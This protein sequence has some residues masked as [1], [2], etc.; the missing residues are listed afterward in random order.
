MLLQSAAMLARKLLVET[1]MS[2]GRMLSLDCQYS[3]MKNFAV[4]KTFA[5]N[6]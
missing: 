6:I 4:L 2:S 5:I 1:S 3:L